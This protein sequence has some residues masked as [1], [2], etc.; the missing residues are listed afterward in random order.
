MRKTGNFVLVSL[1]LFG[2]NHSTTM[3]QSSMTV[4]GGTGGAIQTPFTDSTSIP[5]F[6]QTYARLTSI[7]WSTY[8]SAQ[9]TATAS[10]TTS[11]PESVSINATDT[12]SI[13]NPGGSGLLT[14][15]AVSA[16]GT[17]N[18]AA[19]TMNESING[20]GETADPDTTGTITTNLSQYVG[21]RSLPFTIS[22]PST[23][24][25]VSGAS[26]SSAPK[27]SASAT[28]DWTYNYTPIGLTQ[29]DPIMPTTDI[30]GVYS[31]SAV[32]SGRWFDPVTNGAYEYQITSANGSFSGIGDFPTGFTAEFDV[33]AGDVDY[34]MFGPGDSLTFPA[35]T[36]SFTV[37]DIEP[38][39][40]PGT[41]TDFPIQLDFNADGVTF[42]AT[43]VPEP[44]MLIWAVV[45]AGVALSGRRRF[46]VN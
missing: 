6:S 27:F 11:S 17:T 18:V 25:A 7:N 21:S 28:L 46:F 33:T 45:V 22:A 35:G 37:S 14:Q 30:N 29:S 40:T 1:V 16:S 26:S 36:T 38:A 12:L 44:S 19:N 31:F 41:S 4:V 42:T 39:V 34:G 8:G 32:P 3:G 20:F 24:V 10:N 9:A 23:T 13:G 15:L 43:A 5:M 2:L